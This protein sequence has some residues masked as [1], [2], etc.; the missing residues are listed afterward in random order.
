MSKVEVSSLCGDEMGRDVRE[1][2]VLLCL[3]PCRELDVWREVGGWVSARRGE[4]FGL[5]EAAARAGMGADCDRF[6]GT[7]GR[8]GLEPIARED[9][10][11]ER[12]CVG[13][14]PAGVEGIVSRR[15]RRDLRSGS[16]VNNA[17]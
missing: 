5:G 6:G 10:D 12:L 8:L 15:G 3:E 14:A 2:E 11:G 16:R 7:G 13:R 9:D 1:R 4:G 17:G